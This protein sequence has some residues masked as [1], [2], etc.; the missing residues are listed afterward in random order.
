MLMMLIHEA[1]EACVCDLTEALGVDQ[2]KASRHLGELR[3]CGLLSDE[4]RGKWV[5]Y[6][7]H[8]DLPDWAKQ[9]VAI[10]VQANLDRLESGLAILKN[11]TGSC[12]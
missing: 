12:C 7:L 10:T 3:K 4:R 8:N 11:N 6:R 9:V 5:Y 2:P 1:G